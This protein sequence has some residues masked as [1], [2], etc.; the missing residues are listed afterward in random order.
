MDLRRPRKIE[1]VR[2][3]R[4]RHLRLWCMKVIGLQLTSSLVM[5]KCFKLQLTLMTSFTC[6]DQNFV[7]VMAAEKYFAVKLNLVG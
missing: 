3:C 2:G 5:Q 4:R 6:L 7:A 1:G